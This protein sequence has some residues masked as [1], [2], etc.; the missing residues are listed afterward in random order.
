MLKIYYLILIRHNQVNFCKNVRLSGVLK[1]ESIRHGQN[2][3]LQNVK[4]IEQSPSIKWIIYVPA[5][6]VLS[7]KGSVP[8]M[9]ITTWFT[10]SASGIINK[11]WVSSILCTEVSTYNNTK[12]GNFFYLDTIKWT[13]KSD[14]S[15]SNKQCFGS[16]EVNE[17]IGV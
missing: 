4:N 14:W 17:F 10:V 6:P 13:K 12:H 15:Y 5:P 16:S 1:Y 3:A 9:N 7:G 8:V 11:K 2:W